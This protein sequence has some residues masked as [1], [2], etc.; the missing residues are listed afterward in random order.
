MSSKDKDTVDVHD[1]EI[2]KVLVCGGLIDAAVPSKIYTVSDTTLGWNDGPQMAIHRYCHAAQNIGGGDVFVCGGISTGKQLADSMECEAYL[3]ETNEFKLLGC[4]LSIP[5]T[6][7][8]TAR[9]PN[10]NVIIMCGAS[11]DGTVYRTCEI[12]NPTTCSVFA[13]NATHNENVFGGAACTLPNGSVLFTG[14]CA[15]KINGHSQ[16]AWVTSETKIYDYRVDKLYNGDSMMY[17][18]SNHTVTP[19]EDGAIVLGGD[20]YN[21]KDGCSLIEK[22]DYRM[23]KFLCVANLDCRKILSNHFAVRVGGGIDGTKS[24][25]WFG[26]GLPGDGFASI[27]ILDLN[28]SNLFATKNIFDNRRYATANVI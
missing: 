12:F 19:V 14:G 27:G 6:R 11:K 13:S 26:G 10:G 3:A 28:G 16:N 18:R 5:R 25:V 21:P 17:G 20:V 1:S 4:R 7:H 23:G 9:L 2:T 8:A 15:N 24:R 22:Y